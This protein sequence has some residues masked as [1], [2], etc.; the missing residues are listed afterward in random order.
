MNTRK[1]PR[2]LDEAFPTGAHYGC[3]IEKP[4]RDW[5][6]AAGYALAIVIG[7]ALAA[8]LVQWWST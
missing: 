4:R 1:F 6:P 2:T 7:V 3:A 5:E 8:A